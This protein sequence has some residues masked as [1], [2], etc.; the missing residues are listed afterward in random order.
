MNVIVQVVESRTEIG[1]CFTIPPA[2]FAHTGRDLRMIGPVV[3]RHVS[4]VVLGVVLAQDLREILR[5]RTQ[6]RVSW[7]GNYS[8]ENGEQR[9]DRADD[10]FE[11]RLDEELDDGIFRLLVLDFGRVGPEVPQIVGLGLGESSRG[12]ALRVDVGEIGRERRGVG[13]AR[14]APSRAS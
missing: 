10:R 14:P 11:Q 12:E 2:V 7:N 5:Q 3:D 8:R 6:R 4:R 1:M 13:R 9:C